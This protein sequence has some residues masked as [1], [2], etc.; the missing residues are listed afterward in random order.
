MKSEFDGYYDSVIVKP[1][2]RNIEPSLY[3]LGEQINYK[4]GGVFAYIPQV[5]IPQM[6]AFAE[7]I[8]AFY[9]VYFHQWPTPQGKWDAWHRKG[10]KGHTAGHK[11][12]EDKFIRSIAHAAFTTSTSTPRCVKKVAK[13]CLEYE[14]PINKAEAESA[15][16]KYMES[17]FA[18]KRDVLARME[19]AFQK[20]GNGNAKSRDPYDPYNRK[21]AAAWA[22]AYLSD[23]YWQIFEGDPDSVDSGYDKHLG[24]LVTDYIAVPL[25]D[26]VG[27]NITSFTGQPQFTGGRRKN[28]GYT[29]RTYFERQRRS[30]D[31]GGT[32]GAREAAT[33]DSSERARVQSALAAQGFDPGPSDGNFGTRTREAIAGWQHE[34]GYRATGGTHARAGR[35]APSPTN[36]GGARPDR[37]G[38]SKAG[39]VESGEKGS[40]RKEMGQGCPAVV[41][42]PRAVPTPRK[43]RCPDR[44]RK[45]IQ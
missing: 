18:G 4:R 44:I 11:F 21:L 17:G 3:P 10:Y 34:N 42:T 31:A 39:G 6:R 20:M 37:S 36:R 13:T 33:L 29:E 40:R 41:K 23:H 7:G 14:D 19:R 43:E 2:S 25:I 45:A 26:P 27:Y 38:R 9:G 5:D 8:N 16:Q 12:M 24:Q 32:A 28:V 30:S 22:A 15:A 35:G 1:W